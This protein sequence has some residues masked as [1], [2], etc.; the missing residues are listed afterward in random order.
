[1]GVEAPDEEPQRV[2]RP[3]SRQ[4]PELKAEQFFF[5]GRT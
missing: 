5:P 3:L 2:Q 1:V 4:L